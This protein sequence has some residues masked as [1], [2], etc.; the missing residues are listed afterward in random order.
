M[1]YIIKVRETLHRLRTD[2]RAVV[3]IEYVIV[4]ASITAIV[5]LAFGAGGPLQTALT[6]GLGNIGTAITNA[7]AP[8]A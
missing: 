5:A 3:S 1:H 4:A 2:K 8:A 6:T 7:T